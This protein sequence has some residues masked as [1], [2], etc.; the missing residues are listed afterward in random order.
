MGH[1]EA[2]SLGFFLNAVGE[3]PTFSLHERRFAVSRN[4]IGD[5]VCSPG[6]VLNIGLVVLL[7]D[8]CNRRFGRTCG[9]NGAAAPN[10][11]WGLLAP[12]PLAS[13]LAAL[14]PPVAPRLLGSLCVGRYI[15]LLL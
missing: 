6:I 1:F 13:A 5:S 4:K 12:K 8:C 2:Q 9:A 7:S 10:P 3:A 15:D 11:A 14:D